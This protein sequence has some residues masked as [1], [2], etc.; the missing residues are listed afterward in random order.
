MEQRWASAKRTTQPSES[1]YQQ[2]NA[3]ALAATAAGVG[4]LALAQPSEARVVYTRTHQVI[5][6]NG[7][8]ELDLNHDGIIDFLIQQL[9][10]TYH[11]TGVNDL[12]AQGALGNSVQGS[13]SDG[14]NFA[15]ALHQGSAIGPGQRF[16]KGSYPGDIMVNLWVTNHSTGERGRWVNV[17]R[18][19][20][21]LKFKVDGKTHYGWA[22]L[23]VQE[24]GGNLKITATLT[25]YAYET[26]PD[27]EILAGQTASQAED[28]S[29]GAK[30]APTSLGTLA[31]GAQGIALRGRSQ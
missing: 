6:K 15:A 5:G 12:L 18:R 29:A 2:L 10:N 30:S 24:G 11:S 13:A 26:V 19:Y 14:S 28:S 8:Y 7:V 3:Y 20:L 4:V 17:T 25:G 31:L 23:N 16:R 1:L 21:G 27:K 22:R 9:G